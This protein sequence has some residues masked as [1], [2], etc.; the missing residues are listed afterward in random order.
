MQIPYKDLFTALFAMFCSYMNRLFL[1]HRLITKMQ[2]KS[3][4]HYFVLKFSYAF[5]CCFSLKLF[6]GRVLGWFFWFGFWVFFFLLNK[7][8]SVL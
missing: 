4:I 1:D 3:G 7:D 6:L 8:L 2:K 5:I